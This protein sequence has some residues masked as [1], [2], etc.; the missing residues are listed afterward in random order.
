MGCWQALLGTGQGA[1]PSWHPEV[2]E[3]S[4]C[5]SLL[6]TLLGPLHSSLLP[7]RPGP[8]CCS[9]VP[10]LGPISVPPPPKTCPAQH[11]VWV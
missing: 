7:N 8:F 2:D 4:E 6:R 3:P 9:P 10:L 1:L 5:P 11:W